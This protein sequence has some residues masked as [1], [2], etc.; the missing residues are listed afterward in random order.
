MEWRRRPGCEV[1]RAEQDGEGTVSDFVPRCPLR[2]AVHESRADQES[3]HVGGL[4]A[5]LCRLR[6]QLRAKDKKPGS[7]P[8]RA[9]QLRLEDSR[10]PRSLS[11]RL[12]VPA[13]DPFSVSYSLTGLVKA[14][15]SSNK[16]TSRKSP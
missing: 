7:L 16:G 8:T 15:P 3:A 11:L 12:F 2:R 6:G 5:D 1:Q 9:R 10:R 14:F 4:P 13:A